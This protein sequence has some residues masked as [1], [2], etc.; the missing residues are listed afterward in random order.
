MCTNNSMAQVRFA[1]LRLPGCGV[2][3]Q[4]QAHA[5]GHAPGLQPALNCSF[6]GPH[7]QVT[8]CV[9][10]QRR[11]IG[12]KYDGAWPCRRWSGR[13]RD[14]SRSLLQ[15]AVRM[16]QTEQPPPAKQSRMPNQLQM[17][18]AL[19]QGRLLRTASAAPAALETPSLL[20]TAI[21]ASLGMTGTPGGVQAVNAV[22]GRPL[23]ATVPVHRA[24]GIQAV[25]AAVLMAAARRSRG[26][27]GSRRRIRHCRTSARPFA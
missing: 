7:A 22:R 4:A 19:H 14:G 26:G 24:S 1:F 6:H 27:I 18:P 3:F 21:P 16:Q 13:R 2:C 17:D 11:A 15:L 25:A 20:P 8:I 12:C 10:I 5:G 9:C 23:P